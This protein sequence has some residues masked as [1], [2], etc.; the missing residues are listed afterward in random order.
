MSGDVLGLRPRV[1]VRLAAAG[2]V[3]FSGEVVVLLLLILL[4][5][6][7]DAA[8]GDGGAGLDGEEK[9]KRVRILLLLGLEGVV[10]CWGWSSSSSESTMAR[11]RRFAGGAIAG[12][13]LLDGGV[14]LVCVDCVWME[15]FCLSCVPQWPLVRTWL[16][17]L[18]LLDFWGPR[19][20]NAG[21]QATG[22]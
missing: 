18:D 19:R 5:L 10:F 2:E 16:L 1:V 20:A 17:E 8:D 7:V 22:S 4:S 6:L 13:W 11:L 3:S 15:G 21:R 12:V 14:A 9:R